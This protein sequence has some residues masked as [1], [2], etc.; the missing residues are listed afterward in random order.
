MTDQTMKFEAET[1]QLL[2]IMI[3]SLYTEKEVFLRE[4]ISNASDAL[5]K[6]RFASLTDKSL[7]GDGFEGRIHLLPDPAARTLTITDNGIGMTRDEVVANIGTIARSGT[8][9]LLRDLEQTRAKDLPGELIGRFGVGFYSCLMVA[10]RVTLTTRRAGETTATLWE[11][12]GGTEYTLK[13][14]E[15]DNAGTTIVL[16]LKPADPDD[17]LPDFTNEWVL[18]RIVK[19]YSDFVRYPVVLPV[20]REEGEGDEKKKV[21]K[22][23][24]LNSMKAIWRKKESE[25]TDEERSEFYKHVA[26]DWAD[27]LVSIHLQAEGRS[28]FQSLMFIPSNAPFDIYSQS[29]KRGLQLYV[30]NVLIMDHCEELLPEYLRFVKGVVDASDLPLNISRE[31][32]QNNRQ[33][34]AIRG[35]LVKKILH[36]LQKLKDKDEEKYLT[37]WQAF[38]AV[39]K[40]GLHAEPADKDRLV[41]LLLFA[42]SND[43][44]KLTSLAQYRSRMKEGQ[45]FIYYL[46]GESREVVEHSPH[47]EALRAKDYEVLFFIDPID[48]FMVAGLDAF[49]GKELKSIGKGDVELAG[50]DEKKTL[51]ERSLQFKDC[52][53]ALQKVLDEHVSEVRL[54]S[55][56]TSSPACMVGS[57]GYLSPHIERLMKQ[58]RLSMPPQKRVMEL[59]PDHPVIV[60]IKERFDAGLSDEELGDTARLLH[61]QALLAESSPL[62]DPAGFA[63][64]VASLMK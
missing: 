55:R 20:T 15:R 25:V 14:G 7:A 12:R 26:R 60:R 3:H 37:F 2:E 44:E 43:K 39:L 46:S 64:L 51:E 36:E 63:R 19:K 47:M 56:L 28:E 5:D 31:T 4:L 59:N 48:E 13:E 61:G 53:A 57:E 54:S 1:A 8:R 30:R 38:G 58:S 23:E 62:P 27:P 22:D 41:P 16:H 45:E 35:A 21:V 52:L 49:D 40:E 10:D 9:D 50:E 34:T 42:S 6:L 29:F 17:G 11:Y 32:L 18:R 24:T 33:L